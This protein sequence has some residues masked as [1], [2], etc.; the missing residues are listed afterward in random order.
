VVAKPASGALDL[1]T[2]TLKGLGNTPAFLLTA[3]VA[4]STRHRPP[5][6]VVPGARIEVFD[7]CKAEH[8]ERERQ[9]RGTLQRPANKSA[10]GNKGTQLASGFHGLSERD[11]ALLE[12]S[13]SK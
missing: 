8:Q 5:R 4:A 12:T 13:E 11:L 10:R 7:R 1:S 2:Q 6:R 3:K 9:R